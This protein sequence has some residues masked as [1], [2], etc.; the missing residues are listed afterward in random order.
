[1]LISNIFVE[2][3]ISPGPEIRLYALPWQPAPGPDGLLHLPLRQPGQGLCDCAVQLYHPDR[4]G[5]DSRSQ[6]DVVQP[7]DYLAALK[8][9]WCGGGYWIL[10]G[11]PNADWV[12]TVGGIPI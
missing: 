12:G 3:R 4:N 7:Q 6:Q 9:D 5:C 10:D 8:R 1:M 11:L 2:R